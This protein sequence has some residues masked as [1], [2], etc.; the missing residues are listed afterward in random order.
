[1]G[2]GGGVIY[3]AVNLL[4]LYFVPLPG[5]NCDPLTTLSAHS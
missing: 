1:M 2:V 5:Q 4:G 3:S